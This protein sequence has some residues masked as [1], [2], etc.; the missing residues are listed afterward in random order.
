M[1]KDFAWTLEDLPKD[2]QW[3]SDIKFSVK[4][5][6]KIIRNISSTSAGPSGITPLLLKK[7]EKVMP[8][9]I[10]RWCQ[11]VLDTEELPSINILSLILPLLKPGKSPGDPASYCPV[12]LTELLERVLEKVLQQAMQRHAEKF[13][14]FSNAKHV[15]IS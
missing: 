4:G 6:Q 14:L 12:A 13:N 8:P 5:L 11:T 15:F 1:P 9:I 7:T 2:I 3:I 10:W